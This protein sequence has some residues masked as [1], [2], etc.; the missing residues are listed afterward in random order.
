M[1]NLRI[2]TVLAGTL[3]LTSVLVM[4]LVLLVNPSSDDGIILAYTDGYGF[5]HDLYL[6]DTASGYAVNVTGDGSVDIYQ[7]VPITWFPDGRRFAYLAVGGET[8]SV[9]IR[10]T[11]GA[12]TTISAW[13]ERVGLRD[14][15]ITADGEAMYYTAMNTADGQQVMQFNVP[16]NTLTA[17]PHLSSTT[18][19]SPDGKWIA[20]GRVV[21][22]EGNFIINIRSTDGEQ[23]LEYRST[24]A[25]IERYV[26]CSNTTARAFTLLWMP[27]SERV[28]L[29]SGR[30]LYW[31][32]AVDYAIDPY[33]DPRITEVITNGL[34][35]RGRSTSCIN[36]MSVEPTGRYLALRIGVREVYVFDLQD[37]QAQPM[38]L[39]GQR[40]RWGGSAWII[41]WLPDSTTLL[42]TI[43]NEGE[44][45]HYMLVDPTRDTVEKVPNFACNFATALS[46]HV[47]G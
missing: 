31:L 14:M 41:D 20:S 34:E 11:G 22:T 28:L 3:L 19:L 6:H 24:D 47:P 44:G 29:S 8:S 37:R 21:D 5:E 25:D 15:Y 36:Q 46:V 32:N 42:A 9:V 13:D 12:E 17:N 27:D 38:L 18:G 1:L 43:N 16:G 23:S 39:A 33:D 30:G 26:N 45:C 40:L 10:D 7:A 35:W 2:I 4:G